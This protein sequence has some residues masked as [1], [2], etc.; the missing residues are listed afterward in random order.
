[1]VANLFLE[2]AVDEVISLATVQDCDGAALS[3]D[4][5]ILAW[6][7]QAYR[8]IISYCNR[9]FETA[10]YID[11]Y[12]NVE[13]RVRLR[14]TPITSIT[15]VRIFGEDTDLG[16]TTYSLDVNDYV[17]GNTISSVV[18]GDTFLYN[19][20]R[21][22]KITYIG[23]L[24]SLDD[25]DVLLGAVASQAYY[26]WNA[27]DIL[28]KAVMRSGEFYASPAKTSLELAPDIMDM[29]G[30]HKYEGIGRPC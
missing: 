23:G 1:M 15:S 10:T 26:W 25:D 24:A 21:D 7:K 3:S 27:R 8:R 9:P 16:V 14:V 6:V 19:Y 5:T 17:D 20:P 29:L 4:P 13:H 28:G 2:P 11:R 30:D 22:L 12:D 18:S